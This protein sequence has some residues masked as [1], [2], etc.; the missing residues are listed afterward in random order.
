M[1][2]TGISTE[3]SLPDRKRPERQTG[4]SDLPETCIYE[5]FKGCTTARDLCNL[6]LC[7]K[8][9]KSVAYSDDLWIKMIPPEY[10]KVIRNAKPPLP[11][12][13]RELYVS[14]YQSILLNGGTTRAWLDR[15]TA[16]MAYMLF[17][18]DVTI[19]SR[20][21]GEKWCSVPGDRQ[22]C[23][24]R[25]LA[26]LLE[27]HWL[28]VRDRI[29]CRLL[30]PGTNYKVVF[31]LKFTENSSGC[32]VPME[33]FLENIDE[34][35]RWIEVVGG[36]FTAR[37]VEDDKDGYFIELSMKEVEDLDVEGSILID[38]RIQPID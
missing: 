18:R 14:L 34:T 11:A 19:I 29:D 12:S 13:G 15:A 6:S 20:P 27:V 31:V 32:E 35:G 17:A 38:V 16:K 5:I 33:Q 7:S 3:V 26:K 28:M 4:L 24:F 10:Q 21:N 37:A 2:A 23:R 25:D 8:L 36:E 9:C 22:L 30:S 1:A